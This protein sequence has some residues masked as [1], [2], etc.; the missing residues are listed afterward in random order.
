MPVEKAQ[1]AAKQLAEPGGPGL[2]GEIQN[3][4]MQGSFSFGSP[5]NLNAMFAGKPCSGWRNPAMTNP[6]PFSR[7][8]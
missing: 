5:A 1:V 2:A 6:S 3:L 7:K 4:A 8:C